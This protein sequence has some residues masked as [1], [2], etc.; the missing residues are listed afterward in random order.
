[1]ESGPSHQSSVAVLSIDSQVLKLKL[2]L[3]QLL[4]HFLPCR[5]QGTRL[6]WSSETV[7][8]VSN[9]CEKYPMKIMT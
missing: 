4:P 7:N 3:L 9:I 6:M 2:L 5:P 8:G 1:M